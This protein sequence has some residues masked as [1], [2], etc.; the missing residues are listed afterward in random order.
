MQTRMEIERA[1]KLLDVGRGGGGEDLEDF[2]EFI[3]EALDKCAEVAGD[4]ELLAGWGLL[5]ALR[6]ALE[7]LV[8]D[9]VRVGLEALEDGE[10]A[11][12]GTLPHVHR[13][14]RVEV[15]AE[16]EQRRNVLHQHL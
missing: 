3:V 10:E 7:G 2:E 12:G 8:E 6:H 11:A 4:A 15:R 14:A 13:D 9:D 1:V 5:G 16:I